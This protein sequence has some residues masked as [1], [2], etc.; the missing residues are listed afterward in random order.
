MIFKTILLAA[1]MEPHSAGAV[2]YAFAL[3]EKLGAVV[4]V[5]YAYSPVVIPNGSGSGTIPYEALHERARTKLEHALAAHRS[6]PCLGK[7]LVDM[8]E[9]ITAILEMASAVS[10][11]L[12]VVGTHARQGI[13]RLLAGSVSEGVLR[14]AKVPVLVVKGLAKSSGAIRGAQASTVN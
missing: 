2:D 10:A 7:Q 11:D 9:P 14:D 13:Q 1:D 4:H 6:S 3:A 12:I 5:L 8:G